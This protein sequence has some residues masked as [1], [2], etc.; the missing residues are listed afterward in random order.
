M[1]DEEESGSEDYEADEDEEDDDDDD[2]EEDEEDE[3]EESE[4]DEGDFESKEA[5]IQQLLREAQEIQPLNIEEED[6][7]VLDPGEFASDVEDDGGDT[8]SEEEV[9]EEEEEKELE[10]G[11]IFS[12]AE[13]EE[14]AELVRIPIPVPIVI[15]SAL[16]QVRCVFEDEDNDGEELGGDNMDYSYSGFQR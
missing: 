7:H 13:E 12:S 16:N 5:L 14:V 4:F 15:T 11:E 3:S 10:D 2:D 1:D 8:T 6:L 9:E